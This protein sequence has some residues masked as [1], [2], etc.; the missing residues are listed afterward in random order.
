V[1]VVYQDTHGDAGAHRA[2]IILQST[3]TER[4]G[5]M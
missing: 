3:Y 2:D 4:A 5:S 1:L